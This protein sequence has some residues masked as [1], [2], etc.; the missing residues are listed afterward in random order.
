MKRLIRYAVAT[1]LVCAGSPS[2][3]QSRLQTGN[4]ILS[5]CDSPND[6]D[7]RD[8][9]VCLA[10]VSGVTQGID[11]AH[12]ITRTCLVRFPDRSTNAQYRDII[13]EFLRKNANYRHAPAGP[14]AVAALSGAFPC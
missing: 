5:V 2:I 13:V 12:S 1:C 3:G 7:R 10:W 4:D 14:Q 8:A 9:L 6:P 11:A